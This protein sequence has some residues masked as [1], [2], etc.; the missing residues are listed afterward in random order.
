MLPLGGISWSTPTKAPSLVVAMLF[1][2]VDEGVDAAAYVQHDA[3]AEVV[4]RS[5]RGT[6]KAAS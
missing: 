1:L 6:S 5:T 3:H 2:G 4:I